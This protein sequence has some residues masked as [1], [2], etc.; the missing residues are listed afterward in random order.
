[1]N[2]TGGSKVIA[3][4]MEI[5]SEKDERVFR[6]DICF[7]RR[8]GNSDPEYRKKKRAANRNLHIRQSFYT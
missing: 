8:D 1:M 6:E 3:N 2:R 4:D 5:L 7:M